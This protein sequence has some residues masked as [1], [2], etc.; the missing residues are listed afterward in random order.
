MKRRLFALMLL[1]SLT[2]GAFSFLIVTGSIQAQTAKTRIVDTIV[3]A[4]GNPRS[5]RVTFILTR[6]AS[7]PGGVIPVGAAVSAQL[8]AS[9]KFDISVHP[10]VSLSPKTYYQVWFVDNNNRQELIGIY[11]IPAASGIISL[12]AY[13]V[14]DTNLAAQYTFASTTDVNA[15][16]TTVSNATL[17]K[18][19]GVTRADGKVQIYKSASGTFEDSSITDNGITVAIDRNT[20]INGTQTVNGTSSVTGNQTVG[21]NQTVSGTVT[22]GN[23]V[24]NGAGITGLAGATGGVA[25]IGTTTIGAD[26]DANASGIIDEQI[27]LVTKRRLNNDGTTDLIGGIVAYTKAGLPAPGNAGRIARVTDD[28]RGLWIDTGTS[29]RSVS[30][31]ADVMDFGAIGDGA[32]HLLSGRYG[33]LAAAQVVYP[34]ATALTQEIDWAAIQGAINAAAGRPVWLPA[35]TYVVNTTLSYATTGNQ[36][37]LLLYGAG[38][39]K[40]KFDNR[41]A[42]AALLSLDGSGVANT[43]QSGGLL[44][45]FQIFTTTAPAASRGIHLRSNHHLTIRNVEVTGLTSDGIR[46]INQNAVPGTVSDYDSSSYL[47]LDQVRLGNNG[48][49]GFNTFVVNGPGATSQVAMRGCNILRNTLGGVRYLGFALRISDSSISYNYGDG[50]LTFRYNDPAGDSSTATNRH[51]LEVSNVEFDTN[52]TRHIW[53]EAGGAIEIV[54]NRFLAQTVVGIP[55]PPAISVQIGGTAGG[56]VTGAR[57]YGNVVRNTPAAFVQTVFD[58]KSNA[59]NTLILDTVYASFSSSGGAVKYADAGTQTEIRDEGTW[60]KSSVGFLSTTTSGSYTPNLLTATYHRIVVNAAG[61]F[62][63]N[64]P[65]GNT[66]ASW[67]SRELIL[68]IY[69]A[70]GGAVTVTFNAAYTQPAFTALGSGVRRTARFQY[71]GQGQAWVLIGSW[72]PDI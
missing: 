62:T 54:R 50:G 28:S 29:W 44:S 60:L 55:A 61:A 12:S 70:S 63:M 25:N 51:Q 33:S 64:A 36:S 71:D 3:D 19:N 26:T 18:L 45:D 14:T 39:L 65:T 38:V 7:S 34:H 8:D 23:L 69:N 53:I 31:A 48:G 20:I 35:G 13:K 46:I 5:G 42:N 40:T 24:G 11:D 10:S 66:T 21:G 6:K 4:G 57:F 17:S 2:V 27:G 37:G 49:Y 68:D 15:L 9:G 59:T 56:S 43:F 30:G 52:A 58:I 41:V 32:S 16:V 72:S 47:L 1:F 67:G 22:A